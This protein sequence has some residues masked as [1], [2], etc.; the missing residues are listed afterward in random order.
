MKINSL[1]R[2]IIKLADDPSYLRNYIYG[3][4][5]YFPVKSINNKDMKSIPIYCISLKNAKDRRDFMAKQVKKAGFENFQFYDAVDANQIDKN[6]L[7]SKKIYDDFLSKKYHERSLTNGEIACSL[8]HGAVYEIIVEKNEKI[9][10]ILEDDAL[11]VSDYINSID[12]SILPNGW[13][14][15]FLSSFYLVKPPLGHLV[16]NLYTTESWNGSCAGYIVSENGARKLAASY[17]PVI[18]AADGFVGRCM[19]CDNKHADTFKQK[20]ASTQIKTYLFY[21][22]PIINGSTAGFW[23]TSLPAFIN[24]S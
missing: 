23:A 10:L 2:K 22:D 16:K 14:I 8:S 24:K 7:I 6:N 21:P 18:H 17:L 12:L 3:M 11:F 1:I 19:E 15:V 5:K 20:G 9:A 13:D 4:L